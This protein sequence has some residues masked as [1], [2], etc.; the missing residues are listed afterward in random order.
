MHDFFWYAHAYR[1][2]RPDKL[3]REGYTTVTTLILKGLATCGGSTKNG[4][5]GGGGEATAYDSL[6]SHRKVHERCAFS[7]KKCYIK[8]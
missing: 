5:W 4:G 1:V 3:Y 2:Y 7:A 6:F 8:G